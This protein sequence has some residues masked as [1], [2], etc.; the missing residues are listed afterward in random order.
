[1]HSRAQAPLRAVATTS[2]SVCSSSTIWSNIF[3]LSSATIMRNFIALDA[4]RQCEYYSKLVTCVAYECN[5]PLL[6]ERRDHHVLSLRSRCGW[7]TKLVF[8]ALQLSP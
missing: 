5:Q 7:L 2:N 8:V 6:P 4:S 3:G 1:M